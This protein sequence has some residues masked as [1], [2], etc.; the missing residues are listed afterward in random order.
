[1][2][3]VSPVSDARKR[4]R[5]DAVI[6]PRVDGSLRTQ[7]QLHRLVIVPVNGPMER[8]RAARERSIDVPAAVDQ[9]SQ[10]GRVSFSGRFGDG[11]LFSIGGRRARHE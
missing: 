3:A 5:G 6:I 4:N 11:S 10:S 1:M 9:R 2:S 8:R 7:Q